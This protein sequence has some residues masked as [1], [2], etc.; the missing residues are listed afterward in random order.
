MF[1]QRT[2]NRRSVIGDVVRLGLAD[3]VV[4]VRVEV[5]E[6]VVDVGALRAGEE[7]VLR[8][9]ALDAHAGGERVVAAVPG[10]VVL[11]L[12]RVVAQ[13][14]VGGERLE[15]ERGVDRARV[16]DVDHREQLAPRLAALVLVGVAHD[17]GVGPVRAED[18][19]PLR[20]PGLDVLH[21]LVVGVLEVEARGVVVPGPEAE[22]RGV[23][24]EHVR[25]RVE[26]VVPH[27]DLVPVVEVVVQLAEVARGGRLEAVVLVGAGVVL[28]ARVQVAAEGVQVGAQHARDA[29]LG[30]LAAL[31]WRGRSSRGACT[32]R[33]RSSGRRRACP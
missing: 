16:Q 24:Q 29:A 10:E 7:H 5:G 23:R 14:V 6:R 8:L 20:D 31:C 1:I 15:A 30:G 11:Q 12:E 25:D 26:L 9:V 13:L 4:G 19:V 21:D 22:R 17:Q 27:A 3:V 2:W 33:P 28:E 18:R 32:S